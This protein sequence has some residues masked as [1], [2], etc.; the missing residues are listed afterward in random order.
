MATHGG[1]GPEGL[2]GARDGRAS[3]AVA[4]RD[5]RLAQLQALAVVLPLAY[6]AI[7]VFTIGLLHAPFWLEATIALTISLPVVVLFAYLVFGVINRMR[8]VLLLRERRF[9]GL[10]ESAP[11]GIVIVDITGTIIIVNEQA[12]RL[13]G[14]RADEMIGRRVEMLLPDAL[15]EQHIAHRGSYYR[16]PATRPMGVGLDLVARRKDGSDFPAEISLSPIETEDGIVVTAVIRDIS[17]RRRLESERQRLMAER[18]AE[19]ERMRIALDL[20]DGVI[21]SIY[22]VGLGLEMAAE[23]VRQDPDA[24]EARLDRS[25]TQLNDV[26]RDIRSYIFE[27]RP[28]RFSGD[29]REALPALVQEFRINSLAEASLS[30]PDELPEVDEAV[31]AALFHIAQEALSNIR[32]HAGA[33]TVGVRVAGDGGALVLE[34]RDDGRGFDTA[35]TFSEE[36]NGVRNMMSRAE[37]AGGTLSIESTPGVGTVLRAA[38]PMRERT[39]EHA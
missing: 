27:L 39:G 29:L 37:A 4:P 31:S 38:I 12:T 30:M 16:S 23:E 26:I 2:R 32:K 25:I 24:V 19:R 18:E 14:Y 13:F 28:T 7:L 21:Q 33:R 5:A 11:D 15:R 35:R 36:H 3:P 9:R 6:I 1:T 34:I 10:I 17:D 20:H 8:D 22:A